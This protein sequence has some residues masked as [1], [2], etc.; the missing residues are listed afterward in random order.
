MQLH[1][2]CWLL[3]QWP[4]TWCWFLVTEIPQDS[5]L[6]SVLNKGLQNPRWKHSGLVESTHAV[7]D[8]VKGLYH[9]WL[10]MFSHYVQL[11]VSPW[12]I[13]GQAP[14]S[15]G[16][17]RQESVA[18][19]FSRGSSQPRGQ[20]QVSCI[21]G[22]F[23]PDWATRDLCYLNH[24]VSIRKFIHLLVIIEIFVSN[25]SLGGRNT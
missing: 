15:M 6:S 2:E 4:P 5:A 23:F 17:S 7:D 11:F 25:I 12:T 13:A 10:D 18:I 1:S 20:T 3:N 22:R 21:A 8:R 24:I 16:F 19:S 9:L 14:L